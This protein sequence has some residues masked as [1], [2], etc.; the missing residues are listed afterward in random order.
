MVQE[1]PA[2]EAPIAKN[3]G[4]AFAG[5]LDA[6]YNPWLAEIGATDP[7]PLVNKFLIANDI[8]TRAPK[9]YL[10]PVVPDRPAALPVKDSEVVSICRKV[11]NSSSPSTIDK[12]LAALA[13]R[14]RYAVE[15]AEY[16]AGIRL[17]MLLWAIEL[18]MEVDRESIARGTGGVQPSIDFLSDFVFRNYGVTAIPLPRQ[19]PHRCHDLTVRFDVCSYYVRYG[20]KRTKRDHW[21]AEADLPSLEDDGMM[22]VGDV[23]PAAT[24]A[25]EEGGAW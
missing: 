16:E 5:F 11:E 23:I 3:V 6:R 2:R 4:P 9:D 25:Q 18:L 14:W 12:K 21:T 20:E 19:Y 15:R 10:R 8:A 17:R 13:G 7:D 22:S 1:P 24:G